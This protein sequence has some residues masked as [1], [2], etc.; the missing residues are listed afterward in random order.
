[1]KDGG[2]AFPGRADEEG[3]RELGMTLRDY[4]AAIAINGILSNEETMRQGTVFT[5]DMRNDDALPCV[6]SMLA[7]AYADA[8]LKERAR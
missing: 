3:P 5:K 8:M 2:F 6:N 4:F 1:M 7:Y